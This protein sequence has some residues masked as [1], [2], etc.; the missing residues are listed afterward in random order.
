PLVLLRRD[1]RASVVSPQ[2]GCH[3]DV[4]SSG[5]CTRTAGSLGVRARAKNPIVGLDARRVAYANSVVAQRLRVRESSSTTAIAGTVEIF[6]SQAM[7]PG[8]ARAARAL[9]VRL[10]SMVL[11][12]V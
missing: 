1:R 9:A 12:A 5:L 11:T 3:I 7:R 4:V 10:T 2:S 8:T 6:R